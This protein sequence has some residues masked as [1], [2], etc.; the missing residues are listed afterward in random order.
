MIKKSLLLKESSSAAPPPDPDASLKELSGNDSLSKAS[1]ERWNQADLGYFNHHL[2][3]AHGES[4]IVSIEKN[5]YYQ[6][7]VLFIQRLLSFV[8]FQKAVLIKANIATSLRSSAL[9]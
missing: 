4:E 6:N 5:V 8:I 2:D 1:T 7:V 3:K 9:E